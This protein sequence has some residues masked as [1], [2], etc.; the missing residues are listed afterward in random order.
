MA[1]PWSRHAEISVN[2]APPQR[3]WFPHSFHADN[4]WELTVPVQLKKGA[5][6]IAFASR[7][8]PNFD[9]DSNIS[10]TFPDVLLRSK[11]APIVDKIAVTPLAK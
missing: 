3:A 5:N 10:D 8:L 1:E 9:G 2:G 6:T 7:E 4:F 11:Y